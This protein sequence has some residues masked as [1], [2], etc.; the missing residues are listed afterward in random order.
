[1]KRFLK[2]RGGL[3]GAGS[4][5]LPEACGR[6]GADLRR[7]SP[8]RSA[9]ARQE[10]E[11]N[12]RARSATLRAARRTGAAPWNSEYRGEARMIARSFKSVAWVAAIGA[13]ALIC[14]M[15][16]LQVAEERA[17]L[18]ELEGEIVQL[19]QLDPHAE[20]RARH[21]RPGPPAAA[22]G[23]GRFRLHRAGRGPVRSTMK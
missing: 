23:V 7:R 12:P 11:A 10:I 16:S 19:E 5:H 13:A 21:A 15:F 17:G 22:L 14:Y 2:E 9:R 6:P 4:R 20:D 8:A 3:A 1:M 18:A